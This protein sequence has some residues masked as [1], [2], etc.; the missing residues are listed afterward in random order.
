MRVSESQ[1]SGHD[2]PVNSEQAVTTKEILT[3]VTTSELEQV[4]TPTVAPATPNDDTG[5]PP[6][7]PIVSS[8]VHKVQE[9]EKIGELQSVKHCFDLKVQKMEKSTNRLPNISYTYCNVHVAELL[10]Q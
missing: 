7:P 1:L 4:T 9:P 2:E 8:I 5:P 10:A 3:T 6:S